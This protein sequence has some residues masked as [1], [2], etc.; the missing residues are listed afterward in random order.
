MKE[1]VKERTERMRAEEKR[2]LA[3]H[4]KASRANQGR[5]TTPTIR[6]L[7]VS[8]PLVAIAVGLYGLSMLYMKKKLPIFIGE[9]P[10]ETMLH[11]DENDEQDSRTIRQVIE[12]RADPEYMDENKQW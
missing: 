9:S 12:D 3:E 1:D 7:G 11:H 10:I 6:T 5:N 2:R 8:L 4:E